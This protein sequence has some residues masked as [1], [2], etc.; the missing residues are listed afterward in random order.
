MPNRMP[1]CTSDKMREIMPERMSKKII[2]IC[3]IERQ[4][5]CKKYMKN[6]ISDEM[7]EYMS[8][9]MPD[10]IPEYA[11]DRMSEYVSDRMSECVS[12]RMLNRMS[13]YI[14]QI[15]CQIEC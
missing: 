14:Y 11:S 5:D 6:R 1:A 12:E 2:Y 15:K 4:I 3:R 9:K 10:R 7:S 13:E 8:D